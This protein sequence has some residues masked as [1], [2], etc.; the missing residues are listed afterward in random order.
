[1]N[2]RRLLPDRLLAALLLLL[3]AIPALRA[4]SVIPPTFAEL[5]AEADAIVRARVV[6]IQPYLDRTALGEVVRTRVT[7]EVETTLKGRHEGGLTL[8]FLGGEVDGRGLRVPGMPTF[9]PGATE[10]L[11][12]TQQ[13]AGLC[14]LVAAG[15]GRY[16]VLTDRASGREFIA[17]NDATPLASE[18]DV[19]L[20]FSNA[21]ALVR[22]G[23][24]GLSPTVFS[25][26]ILAELERATGNRQTR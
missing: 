7:F 13:G 17:R 8:E 26:R 11:F 12:V 23:A 6:S 18:H 24:A 2:L 22:P 21:A 9:A 19:Q 10:V 4:M 3:T 15:H 14:P 5:V 20:P 16:R 25:A 1:M